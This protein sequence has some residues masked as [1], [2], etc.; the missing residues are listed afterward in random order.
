[1]GPALTRPARIPRE[2]PRT[3]GCLASL[4]S[5]M[6]LPRPSATPRQDGGSGRGWSI[7]SSSPEIASPT[8]PTKLVNSSLPPCLLSSYPRSLSSIPITGP[9]PLSEIQGKLRASQFVPGRPS[10][11]PAYHPPLD[12]EQSFTGWAKITRS[13]QRSPGGRSPPPSPPAPAPGPA[14]LSRPRWAGTHPAEC[15]A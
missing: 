5:N 15:P 3:R 11:S 8:A 4:S 7:A 14:H 2:C 6:S 12:G 1:M 9:L 10:H 13:R